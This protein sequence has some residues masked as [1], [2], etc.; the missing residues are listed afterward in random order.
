[1]AAAAR[2][3][4]MRD[5]AARSGVM[6]TDFPRLAAEVAAARR[7]VADDRAAAREQVLAKYR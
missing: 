4:M 3:R 7:A 2:E 5:A 6:V 1:V